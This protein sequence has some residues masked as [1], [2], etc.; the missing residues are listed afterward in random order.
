MRGEKDV[1]RLGRQRDKEAE[2]IKCLYL[3]IFSPDLT[4]TDKTKYQDFSKQSP[5]PVAKY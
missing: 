4:W 5:I 1:S 2:D 3:L